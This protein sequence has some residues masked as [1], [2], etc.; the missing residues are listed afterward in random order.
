MRSLQHRDRATRRQVLAAGAG[1]ATVLLVRPA[2]A[3]PPEMEA[4]IRAFVGESAVRPGKVHFEVPPLVENGNLVS[5]SVAVDN[6]MTATDFVKRIAIFN[7]KNP[8]PNVAVFHLGP[9]CG[10]AQVATRI[11]LATTQKLTAIA[12]LNDGSFWSDTA[13]V[14]VTLAACTEDL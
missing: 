7:E 8:Q 13:E 9:R 5:I 4:A 10:R 2:R 3:D 12:E 11:R 6:P 1:L 14:V